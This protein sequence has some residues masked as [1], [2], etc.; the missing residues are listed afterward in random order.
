MV[1]KLEC[2]KFR[3]PK[4]DFVKLLKEDYPNAVHTIDEEEDD[5]DDDDYTHNEAT[6]GQNTKGD[7]DEGRLVT[8]LKQHKSQTPQ[9]MTKKDVVSATIQETLLSAERLARNSQMSLLRS[10]C[11]SLR[12][13]RNILVF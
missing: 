9:N 10:A 6:T 13:V 7:R 8:S 3:Q 11:V 1:E 2:G 5:N 4:I 12:R